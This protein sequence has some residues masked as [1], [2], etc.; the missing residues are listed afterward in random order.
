[1]VVSTPLKNI[2]QN[3][4]LP[5]IGVKIK[6]FEL[7]PPSCLTLKKWLFGSFFFFRCPEASKN[8]QSTGA[9]ILNWIHLDSQSRFSLNHRVITGGK[10]ADS[11]NFQNKNIRWEWVLTKTLKQT[12]IL[13][14]G[15]RLGWWP[16]NRSIGFGDKKDTLNH[17]VILNHQVWYIYLRFNAKFLGIQLSLWITYLD[18]PGR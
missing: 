7:P 18:V 11:H 6:I 1:M 9:P 2:S 14:K 12:P 3:G 4:S 5:Q 16:Y 13:S 10:M 8:S 15:I 17:L